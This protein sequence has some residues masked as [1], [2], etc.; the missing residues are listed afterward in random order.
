[1]NKSR[2]KHYLSKS[3]IGTRQTLSLFRSSLKKK[4]RKNSCEDFVS[5]EEKPEGRKKTIDQTKLSEM[6]LFAKK[7]R[8]QRRANVALSSFAISRLK[9]QRERERERKRERSG[10]ERKTNLVDGAPLWVPFVNFR[11]VIGVALERSGLP[12]LHSLRAKRG[13]RRGHSRRERGGHAEC[14]FVAC[15]AVFVCAGCRR[16]F[17][18]NRSN[19][20][21]KTRK[22]T[23]VGR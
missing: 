6:L 4:E 19:E 11:F 21:R 14:H 13:R 20:K 3:S 7:Q 9:R 2:E 12:L 16:E 10:K 17:S 1:M 8:Q 23:S 15:G 5:P 22:S 18:W